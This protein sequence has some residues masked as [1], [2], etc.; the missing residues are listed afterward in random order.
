M[1]LENSAKFIASMIAS[2][3]PLT[4]AGFSSIINKISKFTLLPEE[5]KPNKK[6]DLPVGGY[7]MAMGLF[8]GLEGPK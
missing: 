8:K 1:L 6:K 2:T 3:H 5:E 4:E 7:E